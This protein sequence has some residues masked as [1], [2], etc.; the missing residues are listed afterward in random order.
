MS[1]ITI[2]VVLFPDASMT[3]QAIE[4]SERQSEKF[5]D[6]IVLNKEKCLPHIS[7][8]MGAIEESDLPEASKILQEIAS[9][10]RELKLTANSYRGNKIPSGDV[11]SEFTI[12]KTAELQSLHEMIMTKLRPFL[13]YDV[14]IDMVF[15]PPTVE[16]ITLCWIKNYAEKSSFENFRPHITVGFGELD[17]VNAPI[18]FTA[19]TLALCHLGNYCTCRKVLISTKLKE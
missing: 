7:L 15:S 5:N 14:S 18:V 1:K 2:D 10:F 4:A 9:H 19:S 12:K 17:N 3:A 13:T 11:V 8:A 6:K 16:E